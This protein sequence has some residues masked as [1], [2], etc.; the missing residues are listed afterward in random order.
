V[1]TYV[2]A[3]A[4]LIIGSLADFSVTLFL[5][6]I[7]HSPYLVGNLAGNICGAIAQFLLSRDWVFHAEERKIPSQIIKFVLVYAG[8]LL[9]SATGVYLLTRFLGIHYIISK[10]ITSV[11]LGLTYNYFLQKE[12]VFHHGNPS[13]WRTAFSINKRSKF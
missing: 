11:T 8:N 13:P 2:K 7:I 12:F 10:G 5:V 6:E 4:A 3:Q 1:I 9:L